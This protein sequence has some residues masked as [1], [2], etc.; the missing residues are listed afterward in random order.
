MKKIYV[1]LAV[2]VAA[3]F[4]AAGMAMAGVAGGPHD[5][6]AASSVAGTD[7]CIH[8]HTPHAGITNMP[9]WNRP[10]VTQDAAFG[11]DVDPRGSG[12]CLSCHDGIVTETLQN[13]P[14]RGRNNSSPIT[15]TIP[16][17]PMNELWA[18]KGDGVTND[19]PI[20]KTLGAKG[21]SATVGSGQAPLYDGAGATG[22]T[23]VEC[24]SCHDVHNDLVNFVRATVSCNDCHNQ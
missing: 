20:H 14:G 10:T 22:G 17:L 12:A 6:T 24:A 21:T 2:L 13:Q 9:L 3:T 23:F 1:I 8:C 15:Y 18:I 11:G 16:A 7:V 5:L 19:H 4:I